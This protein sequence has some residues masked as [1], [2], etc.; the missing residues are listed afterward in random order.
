M[1]CSL[2]LHV[3]SPALTHKLEFCT[4]NSH[5]KN[6]ISAL[7]TRHPQ[8]ETSILLC[9]KCCFRF[10]VSKEWGE[11][12]VCKTDAIISNRWV[13]NPSKTKGKRSRWDGETSVTPTPL[14][15]SVFPRSTLPL[16]DSA[17]LPRPVSLSSIT[18]LL[19]CLV[20]VLWPFWWIITAILNLTNAVSL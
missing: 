8:W 20:L 15:L 1:K 16:L 2:W 12:K 18:L 9:T 4:M 5:S 10:M 6:W 13:Q 7:N 3:L 19:L 14:R 17:F 11:T